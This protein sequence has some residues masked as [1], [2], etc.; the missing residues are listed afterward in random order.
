MDC[1]EVFEA[2]WQNQ[3]D[4][5]LN[6]VKNNV[7]SNSFRYVRYSRSVEEITDSGMEN[8][9]KIPS[10]GWKCFDGTRD[11]SDEPIFSFRDK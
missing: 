4:E 1:D 7:L 11:E 3:T 9:L 8:S 5:W 10:L 2:T 6:Y